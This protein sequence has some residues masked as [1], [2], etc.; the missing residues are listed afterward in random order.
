MDP[1]IMKDFISKHKIVLSDKS[2][3]QSMKNYF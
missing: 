3:K 2:I 1:R